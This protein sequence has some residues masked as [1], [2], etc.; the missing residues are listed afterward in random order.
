MMAAVAIAT[1]MAATSWAIP[2]S[3][4]VLDRDS[5]RSYQPY[6][7]VVSPYLGIARSNFQRPV[8]NL[9]V[10]V[11][12]QLE[13]ARTNRRQESQI[14]RL[15]RTQQR[16]LQNAAAPGEVRTTGAAAGFFTHQK[17]F[18]TFEAR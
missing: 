14:E 8:S 5:S 7:P 1:G 6:R 10:L 9:Y 13:Q 2:P 4:Q 16:Q 12:P 3:N 15:E 11:R 17:Y 18:S